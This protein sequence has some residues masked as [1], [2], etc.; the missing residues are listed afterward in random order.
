[1]IPKPPSFIEED[2]QQH[3]DEIATL[4][5][6][7]QSTP[8][9]A[10]LI[11]TNQTIDQFVN[12]FITPQAEQIVDDLDVSLNIIIQRHSQQ[13]EEEEEEEE[14]EEV[15]KVTIKEALKALEAL[16]LYERQQEDGKID[17]IQ[18]LQAFKADI[19]YRKV[20]SAKQRGLEEF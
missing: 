8:Q 13:E 19:T 16:T 2:A 11:P 5:A 12:E 10:A 9:L 7:I 3:W 20:N 1:M 4:H 6:Q 15:P 14:R 17:R 18:G